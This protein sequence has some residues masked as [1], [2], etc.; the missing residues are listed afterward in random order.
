MKAVA[1]FF[2]VKSADGNG[3]YPKVCISCEVA[4]CQIGGVESIENAK[5]RAAVENACGDFCKVSR[6]A[7]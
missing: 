4:L 5:I 7:K 6:G 3:D 2:E 1:T